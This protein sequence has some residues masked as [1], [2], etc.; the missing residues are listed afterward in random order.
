MTT[1]ASVAPARPSPYVL[2]ALL[3]LAAAVRFWGIGFGLPDVLA[4]PD[5]TSI[6]GPAVGFLSGDLRPQFFTWPM[7]FAYLVALTYVVYVFVTRPF[8]GYATL[9]AFAES[10]RR[11]LAP[12]LYMSRGLSALFGVLTVWWLYALARRLFDRTTATVAALFL[13]LSFLHV[14]DSHFGVTD[15]PMT[16]LVV[17]AV[18]AVLRWR[19]SATVSAAAAAGV[20]G[21]LAAA[22]KYN[23]FGI[24]VPF[25][26]ALAQRFDEDRRTLPVATAAKRTGMAALAMLGAFAFTFF[27]LSPYIFVEWPRFLRDVSAT[28]GTMAAGH[29][30][31][32]GRGWWYYG[33]VVLPDAVGWPIFLAGVAG[34]SVLLA[35]RFRRPSTIVLA[36]PV[37]YYV[38]AGSGYAV[39][40]RYIL[41]VVPFLC[42]TAAWLVVSAVRALPL[43]AVPRR[44]VLC[45]ATVAM[46]AST[47][48]NT[49]L[50]DR[51]LAGPDN[52]AL[53]AASLAELAPPGSVVYQSGEIYGHVPLASGGRPATLRTA[54]FNPGAGTFDPTDPDF[55]LV[56]RSPL[57]LYSDVPPALQRALDERYAIVRT[58]PADDGRPVPRVW[59]QQD[60]FYLPID[61]LAGI[62]RPGPAFDL[63]RKRAADR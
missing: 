6:A 16:A 57:V 42:L 20:A 60:A 39:F 29:G 14:R 9:A 13:A 10:R 45:V 34:A 32:L 17:L 51:L 8:G 49:L 22:T 15:V 4:R 28:E 11:S 50:L 35:T 53:A 38:T 43:D 31:V 46:L 1:G 47:A 26:V 54:T 62:V 48:R 36:F 2:P 21:G 59:D 19:E 5:E 52:R 30:L 41:P 63:Y 40:A 58:F 33:R 3:L 12:F 44:A 18:L 23:G 27:S 24:W 25:I 55:V 61:G 7:L 37:A 56:Q